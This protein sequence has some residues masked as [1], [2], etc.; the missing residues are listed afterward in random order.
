M[1]V[2][3]TGL[4]EIN[5]ALA[6]FVAELKAQGVFEQTVICTQSDFGRTLTPN[7]NAGADHGWGGNYFLISGALRK[8]SEHGGTVYGRYPVVYPEVGNRGRIM[9]DLPFESYAVPIA[10][11]M[12][13]EDA[14]LSE[15][16]PNMGNFNSSYFLERD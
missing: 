15:V 10:R 4:G 5:A 1:G 8:D 3:E 12:G 14:Q 11:W 9:P 7:A 13:V 6:E 2:L 16:F